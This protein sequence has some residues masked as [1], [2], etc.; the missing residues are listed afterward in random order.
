MTVKYSISHLVF[1]FHTILKF[2]KKT[3]ILF[4]KVRHNLILRVWGISISK[5]HSNQG[6]SEGTQDVIKLEERYVRVCSCCLWT[7]KLSTVHGNFP[8]WIFFLNTNI[9]CQSQHLVPRSPPLFNIYL[10]VIGAYVE[11]VIRM[12]VLTNVW[13][14]KARLLAEKCTVFSWQY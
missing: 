9:S 10:E 14:R 5:G 13:S 3:S 8:V 7:S 11:S 2:A 6:T 1:S 12:G 4:V